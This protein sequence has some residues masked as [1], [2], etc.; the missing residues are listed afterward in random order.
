M[1]DASREVGMVVM[2]FGHEP[3]E[4]RQAL[5]VSNSVFNASPSMAVVCISKH[6]FEKGKNMESILDIINFTVTIRMEST[7]SILIGGD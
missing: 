4:K 3:K 7:L 1:G 2:F 5:V 6:F